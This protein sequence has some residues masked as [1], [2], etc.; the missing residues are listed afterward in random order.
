MQF[1]LTREVLECK[2]F[3]H[4]SEDE[5]TSASGARERTVKA[6]GIEEKLDM[7]L[8][9][10]IEYEHELLQIVLRNA[11]F[12]LGDWSDFHDIIHDVNRRLANLLSTTR[13]Y[14]D[15]LRH[16][17]APLFERAG[18]DATAIK[19][20]TSAEYDG[21]L[22]YR[23]MEALRNYVQ[24]R[25]L[26]LHSLT[27][28]GKWLDTDEGHLRK[29]RVDL[30]LKVDCIAK[31]GKFKPGILEELRR[32]DSK[33]PLKPLV[34]DYI[35]GLMRIQQRVREELRSVYEVDDTLLASL[36]ERYRS[37][38]GD[39][40][41]GLRAVAQHEDGTY[42]EGIG[43]STAFVER[44]RFFERKNSGAGDLTRL[45]VTSE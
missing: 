37:L 42:T 28:G 30:F 35:T 12:S 36:V 3:L 16:D 44:R 39:G 31:D 18:R 40:I 41:L 1:G 32:G 33:L 6:A 27:L 22:G 45:V 2:H 29:E 14:L 38:T 7:V 43:I 5:F 15:H 13:L 26:P 8:Q 10:Y 9:N 19:A 21:R 23:V 24:H 11:L 17:A 34:R 25:G 20:I 4:I